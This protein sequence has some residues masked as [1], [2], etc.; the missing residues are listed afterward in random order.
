MVDSKAADAGETST[1][2]PHFTDDRTGTQR[3]GLLMLGHTAR[4]RGR[5]QVQNTDPRLLAARPSGFLPPLQVTFQLLTTGNVYE[6]C[7]LNGC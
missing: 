5:K 4:V 1:Q 3:G 7:S 2:F 6:R